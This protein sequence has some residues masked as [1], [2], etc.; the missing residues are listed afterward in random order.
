M[1]DALQG[2]GGFILMIALLAVSIAFYFLPIIVAVSRS[3]SG[4]STPNMGPIVVIG[5]PLK[6][7]RLPL[8]GLR[9]DG[10]DLL[11]VDGW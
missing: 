9:L 1:S 3:R 5:L 4:D 10:R 2:I 7:W 6:T 11:V 8:C